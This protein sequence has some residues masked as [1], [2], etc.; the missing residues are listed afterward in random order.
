MSYQ[1]NTWIVDEAAEVRQLWYEEKNNLF[2]GKDEYLDEIYDEEPDDYLNED[3]LM[4][5]EEWLGLA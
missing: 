3:D 1:D 4:Q 5:L 2:G